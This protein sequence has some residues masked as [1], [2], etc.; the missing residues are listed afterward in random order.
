M[1]NWK[2]S[3]LAA[4]SLFALNTT[5]FAQT[6]EDIVAKFQQAGEM[7]NNKQYAE[8]IPILEQVID[9]GIGVEG[10][11]AAL[12]VAE[13]QK[14]LPGMYYNK[15][16]VLYKGQ[17]MD[18]AIAAFQKAVDLGDLY[19]DEM[20][21]R[22]AA[23]VLSQIELGNGIN[24]FN[25]KDYPKALAAF[26]KGLKS[27]PG[28]IKLIYFSAK[29][30]AEMADLDKASALYTQVIQAGAANSKYAAE[31]TASKSEL[32]N[33]MLV[34]AAEAGKKGDFA[35]VE[36]YTQAVLDAVPD[37]PEANMLLVQAANNAKKY[38]TVISHAN[39]AYNAQADAAKKSD[40]AYLVGVAYHNKE[41]TAKAAEWLRKVTAGT[42]VAAAKALL[43]SAAAAN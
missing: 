9:E 21:M 27:D 24:A 31:A 19:G 41:N 22:K 30:Y 40:I 16:I 25:S 1:K 13:A 6:Q 18:E 29:T 4:A 7:I 2:I 28:N 20:T 35:G 34:A 12:A 37:S 39:D 36:K 15:A 32:T 11:D 10:D 23:N 43:A 17:K 26:E 33:Y 3:L 8:S 38:D 5:A 42:N 14:L